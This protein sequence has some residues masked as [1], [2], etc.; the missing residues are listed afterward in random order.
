VKVA[1]IVGKIGLTDG[2]YTR[3]EGEQGIEL[4]RIER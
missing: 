4:D 1:G 3:R 2:L